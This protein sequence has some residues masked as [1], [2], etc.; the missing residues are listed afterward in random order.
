MMRTLS[1][2]TQAQLAERVGCTQSQ[3]LKLE[4]SV[5]RELSL[6]EIFDYVR[7]TGSQVSISIGKPP[8]RRI[9]RSAA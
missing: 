7:A 2:F 1:G 8:A 4:S 6:G 9:V 3:I 5:Y